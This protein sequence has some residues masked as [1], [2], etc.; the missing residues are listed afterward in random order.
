M[1]RMK[2][3]GIALTLA[4]LNLARPAA[5]LDVR[6]GDSAGNTPAA[7]IP[8]PPLMASLRLLADKPGQGEPVRFELL[9][10]LQ[11]GVTIGAGTTLTSLGEWDVVKLASG[12]LLNDQN[13]QAVR[14]DELTLRTFAS[15]KVEVP[16]WIQPYRGPDGQA[17]EFRTAPLTVSVEPVAGRPGDRPGEIR[18]LKPPR[19]MFSPWPWALGAALAL[20]ILA[21]AWWWQRRNRTGTVSVPAA[22][23][24]PPAEVAKEQLDQLRQS[25]WLSQG[26]FKTYYVEL[27][28]IL[29]TYLEGRFQVPARDQTTPELLKSLK[30]AKA[31]LQD[32]NASREV[33]NQ[34]DLVKFAK[35]LPTAAE[36]QKDWQ[37]VRDLVER[38]EPKPEP[39]EESH[40]AG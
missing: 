33:L 6:L 38:T 2:W 8:A 34:S 9:L 3:A 31:K 22:P 21:A 27:S 13:G 37:A 20:L 29:R 12:P 1:T 14:K 17:G 5:G 25:A 19:G 36:A 30:K 15:G 24:R 11:P 40:A 32:I 26:D 39:T 16:A 4:L 28:A 7:S 10:R 35:W 23:S 18:P